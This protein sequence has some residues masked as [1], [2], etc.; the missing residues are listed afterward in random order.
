MENL[1][2]HQ[3]QTLLGS[4]KTTQEVLSQSS[5]HST[6]GPLHFKTDGCFSETQRCSVLEPHQ[7]KTTLVFISCIKAEFAET[8][9]FGQQVTVKPDDAPL[10]LGPLAMPQHHEGSNVSTTPSSAQE[11]CS[12]SPPVPVAESQSG[13]V[14][15]KYLDQNVDLNCECG[16][17]GFK[18]LEPITNG[19]VK[20]PPNEDS[21]PHLNI[22]S[23]SSHSSKKATNLPRIVKHKLSSITFSDYS[24]T[25]G[26]ERPA[27]ANESSDDGESSAEEDAA[28]GDGDGDNDGDDDD[29]FLE[30]SQSKGLVNQTFRSNNKD[31]QMRKGAKAEITHTNNCDDKEELETSNKEVCY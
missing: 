23:P 17:T 5:A 31:K 29:V 1:Q 18:K 22:P 19:N 14:A 30:L 4:H 16:K 27:F 7:D 13:W 8:V 15:Q 24:C 11:C 20:R 21:T 25:S 10:D 3:F 28:H 9:C 12:N 6:D 2:E 26:A